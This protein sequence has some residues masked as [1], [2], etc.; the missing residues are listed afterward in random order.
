MR[1]VGDYTLMIRRH[2]VLG[3]LGAS[4]IALSAFADAARAPEP[5]ALETAIFAG[6]CF[7]CME[8]ALDKVEGVVATTSG[9]TGGR[10]ANPTYEEVSAGGTGHAESVQVMYD[11]QKVTYAGL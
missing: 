7:W 1:P 11:P 5:A 10:T 4:L 3:L 8:E 2:F 6:G 9:Y